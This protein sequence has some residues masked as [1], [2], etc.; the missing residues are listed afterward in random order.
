LDAL[1]LERSSP[2]IGTVIQSSQVK[3]L[4]LNGRHWAGLM[5][6]APGAINTGGGNQLSIRFV[7]RSVD[8]NNWT[9]DGVDA[10]GIK[11]PKQE[12]G[13][14]L[15]MSMDAISEF[16]VNSMLYSA[17]AGSGAGGQVQLISRSGT[18]HFSG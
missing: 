4:P 8:D 16:R 7:G 15:I 11:D 1:P 9:F 3:A 6:L 13:I 2:V 14:R 18:N 5:L 10:T 12:T 17:D